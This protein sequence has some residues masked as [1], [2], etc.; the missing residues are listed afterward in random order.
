MSYR[1]TITGPRGPFAGHI[2]ADL[3][4]VHTYECPAW[5]MGRKHGPCI[6]GAAELWAEFRAA[7]GDDPWAA[8]R[9]S[10]RGDAEPA[11]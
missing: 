10:S 4:P 3:S 1:V 5:R 2:A 11:T 8:V 7:H 9:A 6:C